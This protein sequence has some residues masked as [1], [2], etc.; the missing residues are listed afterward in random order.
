M[1]LQLVFMH[2]A[3]LEH[4]HASKKCMME[5]VNGSAAMYSACWKYAGSENAS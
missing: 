2:S 3:S 1:V 5:A 4:I